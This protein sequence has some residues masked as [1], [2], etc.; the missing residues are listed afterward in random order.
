VAI[1]KALA[2]SR[3]QSTISTIAALGTIAVTVVAIYRTIDNQKQ[4]NIRQQEQINQ[5]QEQ[6]KQKQ[7]PADLQPSALLAPTNQPGITPSSQSAAP[8]YPPLS[9]PPQPTPATNP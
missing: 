8:T 5:L 7:N 4:Y 1:S 2:M 6:L 9:A 3:F